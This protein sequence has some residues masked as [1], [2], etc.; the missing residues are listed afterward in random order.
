MPA[1]QIQRNNKRTLKVFKEL[2]ARIIKGIFKVVSV[3]FDK[4]RGA[5][6]ILN[7]VVKNTEE[8]ND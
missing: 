2:A 6:Y 7:V 5:Y 3:Q 4:G 8:D 1:I